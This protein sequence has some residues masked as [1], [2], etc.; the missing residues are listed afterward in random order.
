V[1]AGLSGIMLAVQVWVEW[2]TPGLESI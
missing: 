2:G 1:V